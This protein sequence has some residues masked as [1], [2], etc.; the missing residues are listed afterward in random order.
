[1]TICPFKTEEEVVRF[2]NSTQY[3][4]S[5]SIWTENGRKA[6][7]VARSLKVGTCWINCWL[8]RDLNMPFGGVKNSGLGRE[9]K[10]DSSHFFCEDKTI[11]SKF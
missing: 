10:D 11:C 9:G 8:Q 4:L 5:A 3:G 1:M 6:Q 2:A 7:K